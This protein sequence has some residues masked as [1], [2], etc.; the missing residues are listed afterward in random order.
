[1]TPS[2]FAPFVPGSTTRTESLPDCGVVKPVMGVTVRG[3]VVDA[4]R[5]I[6]LMSR[7]FQNTAIVPH[8]A[9]RVVTSASVR[10]VMVFV[11]SI[12]G[13]VGGSSTDAIGGAADGAGV[14]TS[15]VCSL[16]EPVCWVSKCSG[17]ESDAGVVARYSLIISGSPCKW[18]C[19]REHVE[20]CRCSEADI[21]RSD[22]VVFHYDIDG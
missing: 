3:C 7:L 14:G 16:A 4:A 1:M 11:R 6:V 20:R 22:E 15:G 17:A 9:Q 18:Y 10:V 19:G 13:R 8:P 12:A 5:L 21:S 2:I